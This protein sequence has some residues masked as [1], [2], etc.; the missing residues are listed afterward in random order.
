MQNTWET[1]ADAPV[2]T[3]E[4]E[5]EVLEHL[6]RL[7][8]EQQLEALRALAPR[9]L[10]RLVESGRARFIESLRKSPRAAAKLARPVKLEGKPDLPLEEVLGDVLRQSLPEQ[11]RILN[12]AAPRIVGDLDGH[13]RTAFLEELDL[14]IQK[15]EAGEPTLEP[16]PIE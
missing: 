16:H 14:E 15:A 1:P 7:P 12:L 13:D 11:L 10:G 3:G 9:I 2:G 6:Y 4:S 5:C 8:F